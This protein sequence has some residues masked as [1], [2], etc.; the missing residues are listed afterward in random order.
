[1]DIIIWI[2]IAACFLLSFAGII[3]PWIPAPL[4]LWI[5]FLLCFFFLDGDL[6]MLFWIAMVVL[7]IILIGSDIIANSYF[8]KKYGGSKWGERIAAVGVIV[9]SFI[10]PPFGIIIVPFVAVF[11][12]EILQQKTTEQ[13]WRA[14]LGS[15]LG[16]LGGAVAKVV[17]QLVM[18]IWFFF[19][20]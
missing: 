9:G 12:T 18:V 2:L 14:S 11:L 16:F 4:M 3:F 13:A 7:T 10:I 17:I 1:M 20:V 8:V 19:S 15:L 6:S 5:G